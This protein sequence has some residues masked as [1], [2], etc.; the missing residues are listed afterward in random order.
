[1]LV[2]LKLNNLLRRSLDAL[3]GVLRSLIMR[4]TLGRWT[5]WCAG[6]SVGAISAVVNRLMRKR[7]RAIRVAARV[8]AA[9]L[10]YVSVV[11]SLLHCRWSWRRVMSRRRTGTVEM[12]AIIAT[13]GSCVHKLF[14]RRWRS[15]VVVAREHFGN[16]HLVQDG[17]ECPAK[18]ADG[19]TTVLMVGGDGEGGGLMRL[20]RVV[21]GKQ[22]VA[23]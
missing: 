15:R 9:Q 7:L 2:V 19:A 10:K 13:A 12:S 21:R 5:G 20:R 16:P 17:L 11:A 14:G 4:G 8:G 23:N 6:A 18:G 1:M 3:E 22:R